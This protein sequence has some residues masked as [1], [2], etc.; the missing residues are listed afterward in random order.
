[1]SEF[2]GRKVYRHR[3]DEVGEAYASYGMQSD[4]PDLDDFILSQGDSKL[5][6]MLMAAMVNRLKAIHAEICSIRDYLLRRPVCDAEKR[7]DPADGML[8]V[9]RA[10]GADVPLSLCDQSELSIRARK[11]LRRGQFQSL[12]EITEERLLKVKN[13]GISTW[14]ELEGWKRLQYERLVGSNGVAIRLGGEG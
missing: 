1:V 11:A 5:S 12:A 6:V 8:L 9:L 10:T 13:C 14:M 3:F 2:F 4:L 7:D